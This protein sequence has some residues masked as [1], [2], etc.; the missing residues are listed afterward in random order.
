M[1]I[2][3]IVDVSRLESGWILAPERYDPRR[4][5]GEQEGRI[6]SDIVSVSRDQTSGMSV[7]ANSRFL[8]LDTGDASNGIVMARKTPTSA[9][10]STKKRI[11]EG[12]VIVSRLRPYLRQVA[13]IDPGLVDRHAGK[14]E[15][16]CSTEFFVLESR[17]GASIAFLVPFLLGERVQGILAA[18]QEGGHHPR[19]SERTLRGLRVPEGLLQRRSE[20][21]EQV[22]SLVKGVR[23]GLEEMDKHAEKIGQMR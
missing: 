15:L 5:Q 3:S 13:W 17:D 2:V 1:P 23:L 8:V 20:L 10:G 16:V 14:L 21:S 9:I 18:S 11:R 19:F 22:E 12:H 7:G 6:L 4:I